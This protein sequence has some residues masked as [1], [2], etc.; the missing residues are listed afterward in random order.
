MGLAIAWIGRK[1]IAHGRKYGLFYI[2]F[3][4]NQNGG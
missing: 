1:E 2:Y 3:E 4:S